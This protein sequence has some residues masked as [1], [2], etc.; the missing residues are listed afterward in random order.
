MYE[1]SVLQLKES[2]ADTVNPRVL[3]PKHM[4][5]LD[6]NEVLLSDAVPKEDRTK[7]V[8][9]LLIKRLIAED[10]TKLLEIAE[11]YPTSHAMLE[12]FGSSIHPTQADNILYVAENI[13]EQC[14]T[15]TLQLLLDD[16]DEAFHKGAKLPYTIDILFQLALPSMALYMTR[17]C[18]WFDLCSSKGS[19]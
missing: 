14:H 8:K 5:R 7:A 12:A 17:G 1:N 13:K 4:E 9:R 6:A 19:M 15:E 10:G 16:D 11:M 2:G 18:D 3:E